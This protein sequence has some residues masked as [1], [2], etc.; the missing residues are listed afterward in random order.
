[1]SPT[2]ILNFKGLDTI[3]LQEVYDFYHYMNQHHNENNIPVSD[4]QIQEIIGNSNHA[5]ITSVAGNSSKEIL[6][7]MQ[8]PEYS[9]FQSD[10]LINGCV[11]IST[12]IDSPEVRMPLMMDI[13]VDVIDL[14]KYEN[15]ILS[16]HTDKALVDLIKVIFIIPK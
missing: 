6:D 3:S 11:H 13:F 16:S 14:P 8:Q 5:I 12:K 2:Q 15:I 4:Q 9:I 7:L 10:Q 1:M